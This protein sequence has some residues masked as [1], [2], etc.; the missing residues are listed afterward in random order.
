MLVFA[1][2]ISEKAVRRAYHSLQ[3]GDNRP[4]ASTGL[5]AFRFVQEYTEPG[6]TPTWAELTECWN[7]Q[8]PLKNDRCLDWSAMRRACKRGEE[9]LASPW[10]E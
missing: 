8:H 7:E 1:P 4:L 5:A 9:R 6:Q 3:V 10:M 2:R